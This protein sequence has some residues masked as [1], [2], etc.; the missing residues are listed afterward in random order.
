MT[1]LKNSKHGTLNKLV[2]Q[3]R[4]EQ[5]FTDVIIDQLESEDTYSKQIKS[6]FHFYRGKLKFM[7][8]YRKLYE[9]LSEPQFEYLDVDFKFVFK[10]I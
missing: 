8:K 2:H 6:P 5:N 4:L 3:F 1:F 10:E 9:I 7:I